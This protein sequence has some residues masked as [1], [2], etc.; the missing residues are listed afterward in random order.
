MPCSL[1]AYRYSL[2][3]STA[4][5]RVFETILIIKSAALI[6]DLDNWTVKVPDKE[7]LPKK[8]RKYAKRLISVRGPKV[9]YH[10]RELFSAAVGRDDVQQIHQAYVNKAWDEYT[11]W[12]LLLPEGIGTLNRDVFAEYGEAGNFVTKTVHLQSKHNI[13]TAADEQ[14]ITICWL[15]V[16]GTGKNV[17]T[18]PNSKTGKL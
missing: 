1:K 16:V 4:A 12:L 13:S 6:G 8:Y 5:H 15:I 7:E 17:A 14:S 11:H 10:L 3:A 2:V 18:A 9:D